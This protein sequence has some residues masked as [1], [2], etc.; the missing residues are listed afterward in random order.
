MREE[1]E[2]KEFNVFFYDIHIIIK[3]GKKEV[4]GGV[5]KLITLNTMVWTTQEK[6]RRDFRHLREIKGKL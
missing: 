1:N 5:L 4:N 3:G 2:V 6:E